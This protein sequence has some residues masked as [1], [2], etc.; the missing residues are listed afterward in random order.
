MVA[1]EAGAALATMMALVVM[2]ASVARVWIVA[3]LDDSVV[4][5][6][7]NNSNMEH[8]GMESRRHSSRCK[9]SQ[10]K[11]K[12]HASAWH[13]RCHHFQHAEVV[14]KGAGTTTQR[15]TH[16]QMPGER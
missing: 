8:F 12:H 15:R 16:P 10:I 1:A 7:P 6:D 2:A 5:A 13:H 9:S 11:S 14:A 4:N 3:R